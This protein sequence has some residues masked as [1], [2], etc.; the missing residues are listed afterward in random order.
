M[1][2]NNKIAA[3]SIF[4]ILAVL[5]SIKFNTYV[6]R[7]DYFFY[8]HIP[9]PE[10]VSCF[11]YEGEQYVKMYRK[12]YKV[13]QCYRDEACDPLACGEDEKDCSYVYCSE[14]SVE[15]DEA[16]EGSNEDIDF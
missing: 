5:L 1:T 16:C 10:G 12:A 13:E 15:E 11:E 7:K 4:L 8:M 2:K 14:D 6:V 9:C 3:G